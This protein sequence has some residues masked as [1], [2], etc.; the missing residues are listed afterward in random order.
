MHLHSSFLCLRFCV[1][2]LNVTSVEPSLFT[3]KRF[4]DEEEV[5]EEEEEVGGVRER[6]RLDKEHKTNY[7]NKPHPFSSCAL[8]Q[9]LVKIGWRWNSGIAASVCKIIMNQRVE[10]KDDKLCLSRRKRRDRHTTKVKEE[11]VETH[12]KG[13]DVAEEADGKEVGGKGGAVKWHSWQ[14]TSPVSQSPLLSTM[15]CHL[16]FW[17]FSSHYQI[18]LT[19]WYFLIL[20]ALEHT[21]NN[22]LHMLCAFVLFPCLSSFSILCVA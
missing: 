18:T 14:M 17:H 7:L 8:S 4:D 1:C 11:E 6:W 16:H 2:V 5:E 15:I 19:E 20:P 10:K 12:K 9:K 22:G 21:K 13:W 3:G